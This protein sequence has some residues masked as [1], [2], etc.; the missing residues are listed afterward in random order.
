[1]KKNQFLHCAL[2]SALVLL[3]PVMG[4]VV[5][6]VSFEPSPTSRYQTQQTGDGWKLVSIPTTGT[7]TGEYTP[8]AAPL[9][10]D[11][12]G[13]AGGTTTVYMIESLAG[14]NNSPLP[15]AIKADL[16]T[17]FPNVNVLKKSAIRSKLTMQS[18]IATS[19]FNTPVIFVHKAVA[20]AVAN[21]TEQN[22][23]G[24][25]RQN[26]AIQKTLF[27]CGGKWYGKSKSGTYNVS[28]FNKGKSFPI[29]GG[30]S[31]TLAADLP[32]N[33]KIDYSFAYSYR[34]N[35]CIG[36]PYAVRFDNLHAVGSLNVNNSQLSLDG[37]ITYA[38]NWE[39]DKTNLYEQTWTFF[40]GP[41]PVLLGLNVPY[42]YGIDASATVGGSVSLAN[43]GTGVYSFD[44]TCTQS[45]CDGTSN[46]TIAFQ[47]G[48]NG[49]RSSGSVNVGVKPYIA[50]EATGYMYSEWFVS[51][52]VGSEISIPSTYWGYYG[53]ACGDADGDGVPETVKSSVLDVNAQLALYAKWQILG[54]KNWGWIDWLKSI[55]GWKKVDVKDYAARNKPFTAIRRN[56]LFKEFEPA[57]TSAL[58]PIIVGP[59]N[60]SAT[61]AGYSAIMRNCVPFKDAMNY[62]FDWG[63]GSTSAITGDGAQ[64]TFA[65]HT[66]SSTGAKT[67]KLTAVSDAID[68]NY[69]GMATSRA[70]TVSAL[71]APGVPGAITAPAAAGSS[72]TVGW[73]AASGTVQ[74]YE[75][76]QQANGGAWTVIAS[77]AATSAALSNMAVGN[78]KY[79][80]RAC[81]SAGCS[82]FG[83][84][85]SVQVTAPPVAPKISFASD[86]CR[87]MGELSWPAVSGANAYQIY[88]S[89]S[90]SSASAYLLSTTGNL[91]ESLSF[92]SNQ[93]VWVKA[94][95]GTACSALSNVISV[96]YYAVCM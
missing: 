78:Y 56:L 41:I 5:Q 61:G 13:V 35:S 68:R 33:G 70:V 40:I 21:G 90:N 53:N 11:V 75:L 20:E 73:I 9:P 22:I 49:T 48:S 60:V 14:L 52:G 15:A 44:Y 62:V 63:D 96:R 36:I 54:R 23:Y 32:M 38:T 95:T 43:T 8:P 83:A 57:A 86:F 76:Q 31:G 16:A 64:Q 37:S 93:Y 24:S 65:P 2:K 1:M 51:A 85:A 79:Q 88:S 71:T 17:E 26:E 34:A 89:S 74:N 82:A 59:S 3:L 55:P 80:V 45:S 10:T 47:P 91:S 27:G 92:G 28:N 87:G 30:F 46:S 19:G 94:C 4:N 29:A 50:I 18:S 67:V 69:G 25:F 66:W 6:A 7:T 72:Y 39:S 12:F 77:S 84:S 58:T 42:Y 81:N